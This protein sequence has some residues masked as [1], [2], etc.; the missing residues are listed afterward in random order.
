M[1]GYI[2]VFDSSAEG[3]GEV[4]EAVLLELMKE[5][6]LQVSELCEVVKRRLGRED[7]R[8]WNIRT[9]LN[10]IPYGKLLGVLQKQISKGKAHYREEYLLREMMKSFS[11]EKGREAGIVVPEQV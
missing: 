5:P 1:R 3:D 11:S 10:Q 6:L 4:V 8:G 9:A 7:I 2:C